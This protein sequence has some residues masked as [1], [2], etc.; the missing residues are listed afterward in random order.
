MRNR[1]F[2]LIEIMV[3]IGIISVLGTLGIANYGTTSQKARDSVRKKDLNSLSTALGIYF[4]KNSQYIAGYGTCAGDTPVFYNNIEPFM[5]GGSIPKDP[6]TNNQYCYTGDPAGKTYKLYAKLENCP[7]P[8][9]IP[10]VNCQTAQYNYLVSPD[11]PSTIAS[12]PENLPPPDQNPG[13][14]GGNPPP[15]ETLPPPSIPAPC[16]GFAFF[17]DEGHK[18]VNV[19][20][21]SPGQ[22]L[23]AQPEVSSWD[24]ISKVVVYQSKEPYPIAPDFTPD[25][26]SS[27]GTI[28]RTP[29]Y[30]CLSME[31]G[32]CEDDNS[33]S[34]T[35]YGPRIVDYEFNSPDKAC[36]V[37]SS[38]SCKPYAPAVAWTVPEY[39]GNYYLGM[40]VYNG[41]GSKI[42]Y[43]NTTSCREDLAVN[44]PTDSCR[45]DDSVYPKDV[46]A[47]V[48][49]NDALLQ[50]KI[51][52]ANGQLDDSSAYI[53]TQPGFTIDP[54]KRVVTRLKV[55]AT[56][57]KDISDT[58][59]TPAFYKVSAFNSAGESLASESQGYIS[60]LTYPTSSTINPPASS[61]NLAISSNETFTWEAAMVLGYSAEGWRIKNTS[62]LV[63]D[64]PASE[65]TLTSNND[66]T[67]NKKGAW[68]MPYKIAGTYTV[69]AYT[70]NGRGELQLGAATNQASL[71]SSSS[72][73][74]APGSAPTN[75]QANIGD[76][77]NATVS[78]VDSNNNEA[79]FHIYRSNEPLDLAK[80]PSSNTSSS[81]KQRWAYY[82]D[83][84]SG[85]YY[86]AVKVSNSCGEG[87]SNYVTLDVPSGGV[88][89][90]TTNLIEQLK[91]TFQ[92]FWLGFETR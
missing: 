67:Y 44:P 85:K 40:E 35:Q 74:S 13:P 18:D 9:T 3:V 62:G 22:R 68:T 87:W 92:N 37:S 86:L 81:D 33:C 65:V 57:A 49:G 23:L 89:G 82:Q 4:Q 58:L 10:Q 53:S 36:Q 17:K 76:G 46:K 21:A 38:A 69:S 31:T 11:D 2:T 52:N 48:V 51:S 83:L 91:A 27:L 30:E 54:A 47:T 60:K 20:S 45:E 55:N 88:Q 43:W 12:A 39:T 32:S 28:T 66:S 25:R 26:W 78:W 7:G 34:C 6:V 14:G 16:S 15:E 73:P 1:G 5:S 79:G 80:A 90:I 84:A 41:S 19:S 64:V 71:S 61:R 29:V 63:I 8:D 59:P 42:Y 75:V 56:S 70:Y 77:E 24:D 50:W 72:S